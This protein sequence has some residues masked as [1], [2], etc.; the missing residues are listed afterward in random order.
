MGLFNKKKAAEALNPDESFEWMTI[1][2]AITRE[3][4][5][6]KEL[7]FSDIIERCEECC[8]QYA[9]ADSRR[10]EIQ[11]EM[12]L[13]NE[14]FEDLQRVDNFTEKEAESVREYANGL[15]RL[16]E[17]R[18]A[19]QEQERNRISA[20]RYLQMESHENEIPDSLKNLEQQEKYR[21][22][23]TSDMNRLEREKERLDEELEELRGKK[24]F[25]KTFTVVGIILLVISFIVI[26][27]LSGKTGA[28]LSPAVLATCILGVLLA[29]YVYFSLNR[30][31]KE[32]KLTAQKI[33]K[34]IRLT[35]TTKIK[36]VNTTNAIEFVC[37]KYGVKNFDELSYYW[38]QYV[39][40]RAEREKYERSAEKIDSFGKSLS[41]RLSELGILDPEVFVLSPESLVSAKERVE[42]RHRLNE[43][44]RSIK[45]RLDFAEHHCESAKSEI[46]WMYENFPDKSTEFNNLLRSYGLADIFPTR[47]N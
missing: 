26:W 41:D 29:A 24:E 10:K 5:K 3:K 47:E 37:E 14:R 39:V 42:V 32:T 36:Y 15:L 33:N 45:D 27:F 44:R 20:T 28:D 17:E 46:L 7:T 21:I 35:N 11:R 2:E 40:A 31:S 8:E 38:E 18:A 43:R 19:Y 13:A 25:Y 30:N 16:N 34:A 1:G 23:V 9:D 4:M 22:A 12:Q 6:S